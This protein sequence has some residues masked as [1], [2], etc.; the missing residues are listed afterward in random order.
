MSE[1]HTP[2]HKAPSSPFFALIKLF[3]KGQLQKCREMKYVLT[4]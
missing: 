3:A 2:R 1:S 4:L